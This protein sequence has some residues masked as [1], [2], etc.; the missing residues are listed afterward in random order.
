MIPAVYSYTPQIYLTHYPR[1]LTHKPA[2]VQWLHFLLFAE[3]RDLHR[4]GL[5]SSSVWIY[6]SVL[7]TFP[8]VQEN[9][10]C[11]HLVERGSVMK[12]Y[13]L[14]TLLVFANQRFKHLFVFV[15]ALQEG[16]IKGTIHPNHRNTFTISGI[17][18]LCWKLG[19][20][21]QSRLDQIENDLKDHV[22]RTRVI[23]PKKI[24]LGSI[25]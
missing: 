4:M 24:K 1:A 9:A 20:V 12:F 10:F 23:S 2:S 21:S 14:S 13:E 17:N 6:A 15:V 18:D 7:I 8:A 25:P 19:G 16:N 5:L 3:Q 22:A 11:V